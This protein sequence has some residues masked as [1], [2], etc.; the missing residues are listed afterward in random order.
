MGG[1]E[2]TEPINV[3]VTRAGDAWVASAPA[4]G[5]CQARGST[6]SDCLSRL[7]DCIRQRVGKDVALVEEQP[8]E[9]VGVSEAAAILGWDRRKFAVYVARGHLPPPVAELAGG[10]IW[11]RADIEEAGVQYRRRA[12]V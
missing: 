6:R 7:L 5:G 9:L 12:G 3:S 11:R 10:R 4:L 8:P 1:G 2:A